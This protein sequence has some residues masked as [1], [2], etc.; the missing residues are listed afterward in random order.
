MACPLLVVAAG[1]NL[2]LE[3]L[4]RRHVQRRLGHQLG[5]RRRGLVGFGPGFERF[6][7]LLSRSRGLRLVGSRS[8][9]V[10]KR[11]GLRRGGFSLGGLGDG[12][13][14]RRLA[15]GLLALVQQLALWGRS[16]RESRHSTTR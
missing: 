8:C 12:L 5:V 9:P 2:R 10:G 11:L 4:L 16:M 7:A 6:G 13:G 3:R 14:G 15:L 1:P